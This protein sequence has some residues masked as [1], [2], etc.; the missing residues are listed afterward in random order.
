ML[1]SLLLSLLWSTI[2]QF[3]FSNQLFLFSRM[4]RKLLLLRWS[5]GDYENT[6]TAG[7]PGEWIRD[8]NYNEWGDNDVASTSSYIIE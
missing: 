7:I 3:V 2:I 5:G 1:H 8:F 4:K 6:Y